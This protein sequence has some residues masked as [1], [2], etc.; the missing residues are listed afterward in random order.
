MGHRVLGIAV[1]SEAVRV[2]VIETRLRRFE[3]KSVGEAARRAGAET[4]WNGTEEPPDLPVAAS[5]PIVRTGDLVAGMV[6]PPPAPT[7]TMA[8]A[9]PGDRGF[10]R[11][12]S[13][14][15]KKASQVEAAL[16]FQ[17]IG[18]V[19]VA[20]ED[21]H[22]AYEKVPVE[23]AAGTEVLAVAVPT[24]EFRDFLD[25]SRADGL[26]PSHVAVEGPCLLSLLP[27]T[28][29][30]AEDGT[31]E[32]Q[33]LVWAEDD[34]VEVAVARGVQPVLTR[35][36][37][38]GEPVASGAEVAAS[39]LREVVL[40]VAAAA[41]GGAS[42]GRV[43]V[44]GPDAFVVAG[45]LSEALGLP[46][47]VL[48]PARLPIP[49]A[50][51]CPGLSPSMVKALALAIGTASGGGPGSLNLRSGAF[52]TEGTRGI[53]RERATYFVVA[54]AVFLVLGAGKGVARYAGLTAERDAGIAELKA[55]SKE[56]LGTEKDSFDTVLK[57]LKSVSEEDVKVFPRWTAV[58]TLNRIAKAMMEAGHAKGSS[59]P[60]GDG[61][62]SASSSASGAWA[63]EMENVRIDPRQA[64]LRGE[65]ET[66]EVLDQF[67]SKL[68]ADSCLS[69]VV[70]ESTERI[71]FQRHQ[72]WQR[73]T[74]RMAV[75][76]SAK[77][78]LKKGKE[79]A[80]DARDA[81]AKD[82]A[83]PQK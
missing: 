34:D 65:A 80:K 32:V 11:R 3:L 45:P 15:F 9:Y 33:M 81:T 40:S 38:L 58:G 37:R 49:G 2:A 6:V 67:V 30:A 83:A 23:G 60:T 22:C 18:Q 48:D 68:N 43:L 46:C 39:F 56:V 20:P 82:K 64:T 53:F 57:T 13:L 74:L 19:P 50:A 26:E 31:P 61:G 73:F 69:D 52:A 7:D 76:C 47:D 77:E 44:A 36:V 1:G 27:F 16:P 41:E 14:P 35:T 21:I 71:Q 25:A 62:E 17:M 8:L 29:A 10:V 70:T 75:D 24:S 54:L 66:I 5:P 4:E 59:P 12:I 28:A 79:G 63:I 55:F 51:T 72:G 42:V 78:A